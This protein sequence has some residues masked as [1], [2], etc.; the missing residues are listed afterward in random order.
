MI[1]GGMASKVPAVLAGMALPPTRSFCRGWGYKLA[2]RWE[3]PFWETGGLLMATL[4]QAQTSALGKPGRK[5]R[6]RSAFQRYQTKW[7]LIFSSPWI[8][9]FLAFTLIPNRRQLWVFLFQQT[10]AC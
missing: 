9:G 4:A 5:K 8:V 1:D 2:I 7:G 6:G 3:S 10:C